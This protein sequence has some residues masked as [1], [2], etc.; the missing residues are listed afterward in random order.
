MHM[1]DAENKK[2]ELLGDIKRKKRLADP[3][4]R[5]Q[6]REAAFQKKEKNKQKWLFWRWLYK[7]NRKM[8]SK[9]LF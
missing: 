4:K 8:E 5:T 6:E 9:S 3:L 1:N 2:R 7:R